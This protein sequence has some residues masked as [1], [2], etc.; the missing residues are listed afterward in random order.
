M[1]CCVL[2]LLIAADTPAADKLCG[3]FSS[4]SEGVK[5][6]T[7]SCDVSFSDLDDPNFTCHPVTWDAM[8]TIATSG[9]KE[10]CTAV[11][12]HHCQNAFANIEIGDPVY[13]IFGAM[14]TDPM[15]SM[16]K[17]VMVRFVE[18]TEVIVQSAQSQT[19]NDSVLFVEWELMVGYHVVPITSLGESLFVLELGNNKIAVALSYSEWPSC[20]TDTSY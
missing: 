13:K 7:C 20:F 1:I 3:H 19:N 10:E 9:S 14:P 12:Q 5:R 2:I 11:S 18:E 4:Y 8:H 17:G 6:L 15:H 16:H